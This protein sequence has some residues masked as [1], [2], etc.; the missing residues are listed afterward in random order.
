M[1]RVA[2]RTIRFVKWPLF[3]IVLLL[4]G[5]YVAYGIGMFI[6]NQRERPNSYENERETQSLRILVA[7]ISARRYESNSFGGLHAGVPEKQFLLESNYW[8]PAGG[9]YLVHGE[10]ASAIYQTNRNNIVTRYCAL[11]SGLDEDLLR[12]LDI[13]VSSNRPFDASAGII[14]ETI[15]LYETNVLRDETQIITFEYRLDANNTYTVI[16]NAIS[17]NDPRFM[18]RWETGG[19]MPTHHHAEKIREQLA[20]PPART[21]GVQKLP[22]SPINDPFGP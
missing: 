5:S 8:R 12:S 21:Q 6:Y 4:C 10:S 1:K 9:Q 22:R 15:G 3:A 20:H 13:Y 19:L 17:P 18:T 7:Q 16:V 14:D 2:K 11:V